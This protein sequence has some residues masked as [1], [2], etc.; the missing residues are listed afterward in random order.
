MTEPSTPPPA[1]PASTL[2]P[3]WPTLSAEHRAQVLARLAQ[4]LLQALAPEARHDPP[5]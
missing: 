5:G 3:I 2:P 4:I 1:P